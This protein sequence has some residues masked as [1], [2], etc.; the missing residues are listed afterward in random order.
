MKFIGFSTAMMMIIATLLGA[1]CT[2]EEKQQETAVETQDVQEDSTEEPT[3]DSTEDST[4]EPTEDSTEDS[5]EEPV[6]DSTEEPAEAG[7]GDEARFRF[8]PHAEMLARTVT[9]EY[10]VMEPMYFG[11][12]PVL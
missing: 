12:S 1:G 10:I 5:T 8:F 2:D 11:K 9:A 4:E 3:E 6:E 7:A